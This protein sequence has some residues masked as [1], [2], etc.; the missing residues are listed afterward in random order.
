V[1]EIAVER[2]DVERFMSRFRVV[3]TEGGQSSHHEVTLSSS[4]FERL[5]GANRSPE[6][7]VRACF[8]FLLER[9]PMGSILPSFDVASIGRYF[10][11]FERTITLG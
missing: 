11:E 1:A 9:E 3:V 6:D 8:E 2:V 4:D 5:G 10:P 7:L